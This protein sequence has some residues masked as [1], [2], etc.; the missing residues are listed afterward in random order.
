MAEFI[1]N[2][3]D[4][5]L[6]SGLTDD[7]SRWMS[8]LFQTIMTLIGNGSLIDVALNI[9]VA[10]ACSMLI[11]YFFMD[12]L[13][14]AKR[15]MFSFEKL[16]VSF[17]KFLAAFTVLLC[18]SDILENVVRIGN[19]LYKAMLESGNDSL[20]AAI[21]TANGEMIEL[22]PDIPAS[23]SGRSGYSVMPEWTEAVQEA[24]EDEF[25]FGIGKVI[26][27][28]GLIITS[29]VINL[30]AIVARIA[31]YFICA[32]NAVMIIAR[33]S[34]SPIAVVQLFED[35]TKSSGMRYLKGL[36]ADCITMAVI[37]II[38][39][40]ATAITNSIVV[41]YSGFTEVTVENLRSVFTFRNTAVML[42]PQLVAVGAMATGSKVAH[43][44]MGA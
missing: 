3:V 20:Q 37:I 24:F 27:N 35:G 32:S 12:L 21:T 9:F 6:G 38:L 8:D 28:F 10:I 40:A 31:G 14:Q 4:F 26:N 23:D 42:V 15:D 30:I 17:I 22:F 34:F 25:S 33:I 5:M 19:Y 2:A 44:I 16:I 36:V 41:D 11:L 29:A 39:Y 43:D 13:D 7:M 1:Y 18:L